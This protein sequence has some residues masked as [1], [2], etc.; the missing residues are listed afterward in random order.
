MVGGLVLS[1][2]APTSE[3][4][5]AR[6]KVWK[7]GNGVSSHLNH[8][9]AVLHPKLTVIESPA[10]SLLLT[11]M[12]DVNSTH[13]EFS[14][15]A[16]RLMRLLAEEALARMPGVHPVIVQTPTRALYEGLA[17]VP[18]SSVTCVSVV[19]AGDTLLEAVRRV[20]PAV[21]VGKVLI[22]RDE[23]SEDKTPNLLYVKLP[24][25]IADPGCSV[26]LCDPMC[27]TGG[28]ATCALDVLVKEHGVD[29]NRVVF[30]N[31]VACPEGLA[32]MQEKYPQVRIITAAVDERLNADRY[33]LP[34]L[35]DFGDRF[36]GT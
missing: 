34:G 32:V 22:Q 15:A 11:T 21:R 26:L 36:L 24:P 27:A 6:S 7:A 3:Y 18:A 23:S 12:R 14:V 29:P 10:V 1:A 20:A 28:S 19:R 2:A 16:D 25:S 13:L 33:I 9:Y 8:P 17:A 5:P 31:V 35:G 30:L 4:T